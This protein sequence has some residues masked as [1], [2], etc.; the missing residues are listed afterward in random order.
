MPFY[1]VTCYL[2]DQNQS[3]APTFSE[4]ARVIALGGESSGASGGLSWSRELCSEGYINVS[5]RPENVPE[6]MKPRLRDM[7][8]N[9]MELGVF[10]DGVLVQRGPLI[11]WQIEGNSLVL[12][13][14]GIPYYLRYMM[15]YQDLNFNQD[16]AF[17]VRDL[18]DHF[19]AANYGNYGIDTSGITSHGVTRERE[20]LRTELIN[21][22][23]EIHALGEA[24]NGFDIDIDYTTRQLI[25][26]NPQQG[27]DKSAT[28]ILDARGLTNPNFAYSLAAGTFAASAMG[29]GR[30]KDDDTVF[31]WV[32]DSPTVIAFGQSVV[33]TNVFGVNTQAEIDS[34]TTQAMV[35]SRN[36]YFVPSK[37]YFSV[38]GA[39]IDD[40][41]VG[42]RTTFVYDPGFGE[43]TLQQD[44][45]N[46]NVSVSPDGNEKL[47]VEFV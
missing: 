14:R 19:Q 2:R 47:G 27:T 22:A 29:A 33:A 31:A 10:R 23:K 39:S 36:P 40:F 3:A 43:V 30:T 9:P 46:I 5:T 34:Y 32:E 25:L 8:N 37:E 42:D 35:L 44:V 11:S 15:M 24:D 28:V 41:D 12:Q 4:L 45:K 13:A 17:I 21:I 7:K 1:E 26:T 16:Q 18:I 6:T 20:Y 38:T